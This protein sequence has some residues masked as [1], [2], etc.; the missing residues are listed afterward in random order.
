MLLLLD[1]KTDAEARKRLKIKGTRFVDRLREALEERSSLA[2]APR[3]G[4]PP[5]YTP[6]ILDDTLQCFD[7][8]AY[9]LLD[10]ADFFEELKAAGVFP[11]TANE[12]GF[13][14]AFKVHLASYGLQLKWGRRYLAFALTKRYEDA[15]Y[16][17]CLENQEVFTDATVGDFWFCDEI[18]VEEGGHPKGEQGKGCRCRK[19][20]VQA[21]TGGC[22]PQFAGGRL[23]CCYVL[24]TIT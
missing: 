14:H 22:Y 17:W 6:D 18:W 5:T 10:K 9:Q 1:G 8:H 11:I 7:L 23:L 21:G 12:S 15:R 20:P 16:S 13:Y 2:E 3:P 4:R 19:M 24:T